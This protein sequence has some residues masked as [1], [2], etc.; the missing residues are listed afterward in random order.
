VRFGFVD[1]NL[2]RGYCIGLAE[3][4]VVKDA[5][6]WK[7]STKTGGQLDVSKNGCVE[8]W[9]IYNEFR[10]FLNEKPWENDEHLTEK[11]VCNLKSS[12]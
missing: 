4:Q 8:K 9:W 5:Q 3:D 11:C 10:A 12:L 7:N 6:V 1:P 2:G